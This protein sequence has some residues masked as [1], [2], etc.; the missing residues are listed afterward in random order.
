[1]SEGITVCI[2]A[3]GVMVGVVAVWRGGVIGYNETNQ[4]DSP[5]PALSQSNNPWLSRAGSLIVLLDER[6]RHTKRPEP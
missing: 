4:Y 3:C 2:V 1:M 6:L 5:G